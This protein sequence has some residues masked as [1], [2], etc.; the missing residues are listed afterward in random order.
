M[1]LSR[2]P[3]D[4]IITPEHLA[5]SG[6][7][8]VIDSVLGQ[9]YEALSRAFSVAAHRAIE[10]GRDGVGKVLWLSADICAMR[11]SVDSL[12]GTP[13]SAIAPLGYKTVEPDYLTADDLAVL[14][15]MCE[16]ST[17][18][19]LNARLHDLR[20]LMQR[21]REVGHAL[22]AIDAYRT[23]PLDSE[24]WKKDGRFCWTRVVMLVLGPGNAKRGLREE[25]EGQLM[26]A[27]LSVSKAN[28]F[29]ARDIAELLE[30]I[31]TDDS[32]KRRV[33]EKLASLA[34][35]FDGDPE[36][37]AATVGGSLY[38]ASSHWFRKIGDASNAAATTARLAESFVREADT[39]LAPPHPSYGAASG[40]YE[41]AIKVYRSIPRD[42]RES[43]SVDNR[44]A[45]LRA[46]LQSSGKRA[47]E[48]MGQVAGESIDLS[49]EIDKAAQSVRSKT[50]AQALLAFVNLIP[51]VNCTKLRERVLERLRTPSLL[52]RIPR[53]LVAGDGRVV[54]K[55]P[56]LDSD[57]LTNPGNDDFIRHEMLHEY[58]FERRF[59][60]MADILPA[61]D[62]LRVEHRFTEG[63]FT[64]I[65]SRSPIVP[66]G[67]ERLFG[68]ALLAGV[69][70]DFVGALHV[71]VPQI[72][73]MVRH[74]LKEAGART[75]TLD[76]DGVETEN[77][78][79]TLIDLPQMTLIFGVDLAFE[80]RALFTDA[81]GPNLRNQV[82]HGLLDADDCLS[83]EV[84]YAW[85]FGLRIV[86]NT[87]WNRAGPS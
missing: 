66:I 51:P 65:A 69:E 44:I 28:W 18:P 27:F 32:R 40:F 78:M 19:W 38:R 77:G 79:G 23:I 33:A 6:W 30:R 36:Q 1:S 2:F 41:Q 48:E 42:E 10:A 29:R 73:N 55:V 49:E 11:L 81:L 52:H 58:V 24:A 75:T 74:H 80:L 68:K 43:L 86:F 13:Q 9:G 5:D 61:L 63:D 46:L 47:L 26:D 25:V 82:A 83:A 16:T 22:S 35:E 8:Y 45:E 85:W 53:I 87:F 60:V 15:L 37:V 3:A 54:A 72:E 7:M 31:G 59:H 14:G 34:G 76:K 39:R 57:D 84:V 50:S 62:V 56:A 17:D 71:L 20:W 70:H 64:E 4:V 21:P 12:N 67:R